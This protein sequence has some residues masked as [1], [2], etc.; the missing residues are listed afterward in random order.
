MDGETNVDAETSASVTR[1]VKWAADRDYEISRQDA[2]DV[3]ESVAAEFVFT[4]SEDD[5]DEIDLRSEQDEY[6]ANQDD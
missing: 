3:L 4:G 1:L 5:S 2:A 6:D